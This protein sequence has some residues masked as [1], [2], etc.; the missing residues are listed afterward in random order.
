VIAYAQ[1]I[2]KDLLWKYPPPHWKVE[3]WP[4]ETFLSYP[5]EL[6]AGRSITD[7]LDPRRVAEFFASKGMDGNVWFQTCFSDEMGNL[8]R[9]RPQKFPMNE[10]QQAGPRF[11]GPL[12]HPV[13]AVPPPSVITPMYS[14]TAKDGNG[15]Q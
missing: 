1:M 3:Q 12:F 15:E 7:I 10:W 5:R 2:F 4:Y 13:V 9:S 11:S 14:P 8:Y 6:E